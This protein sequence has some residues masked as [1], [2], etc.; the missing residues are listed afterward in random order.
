MADATAHE[1][2]AHEDIVDAMGQDPILMEAAIPA[3]ESAI[4][5]AKIKLQTVLGT[6][7]APL[8]NVDLFMIN[9]NVRHLNRRYTLRLT[10]GLLRATPTITWCSEVDGTYEE[11]ENCITDKRRGIVQAPIDDEE[12][13]WYVKVEY[14]SGYVEDETVPE[15]LRQ[16]LICLVPALLLSTSAA[17][18]ED[19]KYWRGEHAKATS[20]E[21]FS[22][23]MV[24]DF[25]RRAGACAKPIEHTNTV[26][27]V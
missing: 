8:S 3:I 17:N 1:M 11:L 5:R 22:V 21:G 9:S 12:A 24:E 4:A 19:K 2:V 6:K 18:A 14:D 16:G 7:F 26:L 27:Q 15:E 23:D 25:T 13:E 20:L 10:N